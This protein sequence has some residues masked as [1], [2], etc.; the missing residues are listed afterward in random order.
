L[1]IK[2]P[3]NTINEKNHV[4]FGN[5]LPKQIK[6]TSVAIIVSCQVVAITHPGA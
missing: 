4:F 5:D 3:D 2:T 6:T 1:T